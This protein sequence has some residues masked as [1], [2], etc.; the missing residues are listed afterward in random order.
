[1]KS[2]VNLVNEIKEAY[3]LDSLNHPLEVV[4]N[5][6]SKTPV[7]DIAVIG[8]FKAGKS[9]F[10]NNFIGVHVLPVGVLPVTS[11]ITS[12]VY[13][14]QQKAFIKHFNLPPLEIHLDDIKDYI[15]ESSNPKN[16]KQ[17]EYVEIELPELISYRNIRFIDTPGIGSLFK[18]N[19]AV[20]ENW[21]P[22]AG[23]TMMMINSGQP[24]SANDFELIR[25][26][27]QFCP[28]V[29]IILSKADQLN[30]EQLKEVSGYIEDSIRKE[31]NNSFPVFN[32]SIFKNT[33][34]YNNDI[35]NRVLLPIVN[36]FDS[37]Y[38]NI[39]QHKALSLCKAGIAYLEIALK[40]SE[41]NEAERKSLKAQVLDEKLNA[42]YINNDLLIIINNHKARIREENRLHL[43]DKYFKQLQL[44]IENNFDTSFITWKGNLQKLTG[45]YE[46]WISEILNAEL[47]EIM[48]Y[49]AIRLKKVI[50]E[51]R[52]HITYYIES[53]R[54]K[55]NDNL[56]RVLEKKLPEPDLEI[57][58][59]LI[60]KPDISIY[61]AFDNNLDTLWFLIPMI[62]FRNSF[63]KYFRNKIESETEKNL[64]RLS[65]L[66]SDQINAI[67]NDMHKQAMNYLINELSTVEKILT[68]D[69]IQ[70]NEQ[71]T[72][73]AKLNE[74][75]SQVNFE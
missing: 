25:E 60:S 69:N 52:K 74:S 21:L 6:L 28:E 33:E 3:G 40:T 39:L 62:L 56:A 15:T 7:I 24:L 8:Q 44:K 66:Y 55:L 70:I 72:M 68:A 51:E 34:K 5:L 16:H 30:D 45:K 43:L 64:T 4:N 19:T 13:G 49:E 48:I 57:I 27:L 1:M 35:K 42:A 14:K 26:A 67:M 2:L 10:I 12:L 61:W 75:M 65:S 38:K 59:G 63:K 73:L 71:K 50:E 23:I 32:Y 41:Y 37:R 17:V 58:A 36:N 47:S 22:N 9:S 20:T 53:V 18:H 46:L 31:F 11:I 29:T 54:Q